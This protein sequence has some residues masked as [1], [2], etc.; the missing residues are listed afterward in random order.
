MRF[1]AS[2]GPVV[3]FCFGW[4]ELLNC[5]RRCQKC[6]L[7]I[8]NNSAITR[9]SV[10]T[11]CNHPA[12]PSFL[13]EAKTIIVQILSG[14]RYLN[15][16][17]SVSLSA[18]LWGLVKY[19]VCFQLAASWLSSVWGVRPEDHSLW[20]QTVQHLL[21]RRPGGL[22]RKIWGYTRWLVLQDIFKVQKLSRYDMII[23]SG[24]IEPYWAFGECV[25]SP[26]V[27]KF[28][29]LYGPFDA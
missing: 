17:P 6:S 3:R 1:V 13:Q 23:W 27:F 19:C 9:Y 26:F 7:Q 20:H 15:V 16:G 2:E 12:S 29:A 8:S 28:T 10:A 24:M 18:L 25:A 5:A 21:P 14:L 4:W 11:W 22:S